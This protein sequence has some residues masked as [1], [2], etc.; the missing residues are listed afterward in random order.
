VHRVTSTFKSLKPGTAPTIERADSEGLIDS[1]EEVLEAARMEGPARP[2]E[3][4]AAAAGA[5][6]NRA[7]PRHG[8]GYQK[9]AEAGNAGAR[10]ALS[11]LP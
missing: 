1:V 4:G 11:R 9:A 6:Q 8:A 7:A 2:P 10:Q 5:R 3:G